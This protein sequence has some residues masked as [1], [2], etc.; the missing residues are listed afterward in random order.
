MGTGNDPCEGRGFK[1]NT[2]PKNI[3]LS[4]YGNFVYSVSV[5]ANR[6]LNDVVGAYVW[7]K[8]EKQYPI[9]AILIGDGLYKITLAVLEGLKGAEAEHKAIE[10]GKQLIDSFEKIACIE[11]VRLLKTTE[12][13][14]TTAFHNAFGRIESF[15]T[16]DNIFREAIIKDAFSYVDRQKLNS[17]L[18]I[19]E[20][21]A[22]A[23]SV[24]YLKQEV[25]IYLL[26]AEQGWLV[27]FY[28]GKEI[29][30]L[31]K[32]MTGEIPTAPEALK[33]RVNVG[34]QRKKSRMSASPSEAPQPRSILRCSDGVSARRVIYW[35]APQGEPCQPQHI[36]SAQPCVVPQGKAA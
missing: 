25:A 13:I 12:L 14:A 9:D 16:S 31:A 32:I 1:K 3:D 33:R 26:L 8:E 10:A 36:G 11:G 30:T 35:K 2:T 24:L 15:F 34:L 18:K 19:D 23:L 22:K 21:E 27:D 7:A 29:P 20:M 4:N 28:L 6:S 5:G 17:A